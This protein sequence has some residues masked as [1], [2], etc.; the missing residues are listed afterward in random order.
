[1]RGLPT[2]RDPVITVLARDF[3]TLQAQTLNQKSE[4]VGG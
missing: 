4:L 1:M 3:T 2:P